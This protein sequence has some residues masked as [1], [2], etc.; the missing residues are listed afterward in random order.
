MKK[1]RVKIIYQ[2]GIPT[3]PAKS[4]KQI[5]STKL[6]FFAEFI[7]QAWHDEVWSIFQCGGRGIFKTIAGTG[8]G[9]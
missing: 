1:S 4:L 3:G 7:L 2:A 5:C 6:G 8:F 9:I